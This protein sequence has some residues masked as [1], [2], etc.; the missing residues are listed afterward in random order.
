MFS[1]PEMCVGSHGET[2]IKHCS[3]VDLMLVSYSLMTIPCRVV[4][5]ISMSFVFVS[6]VG[7]VISTLPALQVTHDNDNYIL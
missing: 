2:R 3:K 1:V 4:S 6:I 5:I 7:M